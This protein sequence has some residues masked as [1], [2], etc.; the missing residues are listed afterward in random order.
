MASDENYIF[1]ALEA[2]P[3]AIHEESMGRLAELLDGWRQRDTAL[4]VLVDRARADQTAL[5][6]DVMSDVLASIMTQVVKTVG[7][8]RE[9]PRP[10]KGE[11]EVTT[12]GLETYV[13]PAGATMTA[14]LP[15]QSAVALITAEDV[16]IPA[17]TTVAE[18]V[19]VATTTEGSFEG[20]GPQPLEPDQ[21]YNWLRAVALTGV[22]DLGGDGEDDDQYLARGSQRL[23]LLADQIILPKDAERFI[24]GIPGVG[25]VLVLDQTKVE[26]DGSRK[27]GVDRCVTVVVTGPDGKV[28]TGMDGVITTVE[29]A[30]AA[31][32]EVNFHWFVVP[33][34]YVN[35]TIALTV[36]VFEDAY[37]DPATPSRVEQALRDWLSPARWGARDGTGTWEPTSTVRIGDVIAVADAVPGVDYVQPATIK[38]NGVNEDAKLTAP[39]AALPSDAV[40]VDVTVQK[41]VP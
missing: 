9:L 2:D 39:F 12:D 7:I 32:R 5:L 33:P 4:E 38:I 20:L 19:R 10:A 36:A 11:I 1:E 29:K 26:A 18:G 16:V 28:S 14:Y 31:R 13:L 41:R 24:A 6:V 40:D 34:T 35:V 17:G 23:Q 15:D 22:V 37:D 8:E 21:A 25:R 30:L 27:D 3:E